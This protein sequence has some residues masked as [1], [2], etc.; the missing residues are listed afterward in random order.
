MSSTTDQLPSVPMEAPVKASWSALPLEL[1]E[2]IIEAFLNNTMDKLEFRKVKHIDIPYQALGDMGSDDSIDADCIY[3]FYGIDMYLEKHF[4][5]NVAALI[6]SSSSMMD[7]VI[8]V[9]YRMLNKTFRAID[10]KVCHPLEEEKYYKVNFE[11][12]LLLD[13]ECEWNVRR[14]LLETPEDDQTEIVVKSACDR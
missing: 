14:L 10:D 8:Q 4:A 5:R 13:L 3:C 7:L 11:E 2:Q 1:K 9:A 12:N 6:R